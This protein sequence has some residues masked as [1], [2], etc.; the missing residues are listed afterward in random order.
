MGGREIG[1]TRGLSITRNIL[2]N[3]FLFLKQKTM[4]K[5]RRSGTRRVFLARD[6]GDQAIRE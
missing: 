4:N 6:C 2:E 1:F 3:L 5:I